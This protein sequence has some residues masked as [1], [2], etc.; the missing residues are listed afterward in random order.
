MNFRF[1]WIGKTKDP[2]WRALQEEY[3]RRLSHFAA[4]SIAE[5][6]DNM[7]ADTTAEAK[8]ILKHLS[9]KDLV[10]LLDVDGK[11]ISSHALADTVSSWQDRSIR[12]I[13]FVIGGAKGVASTVA[14]RAD[15]RLSLS[16]LTFTHEMSRVLLLEQLYRA[17]CIINRFPY[18]K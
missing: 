1:V 15:I 3:Y 8:Q 5:I 13:I 9:S 12:D 10:V 14:E 18:Q 11:Q 6:K 4:C 2:N 17:F 7:H 16:F